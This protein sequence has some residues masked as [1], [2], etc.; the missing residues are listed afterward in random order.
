MELLTVS[1]VAKIE[2]ISHTQVLRRI[3]R[4]RYPSAV[5]RSVWLI[6]RKDL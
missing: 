2:G 3:R 1:E 6:P 5:F 4:K